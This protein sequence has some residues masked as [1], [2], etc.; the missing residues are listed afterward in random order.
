MS[1]ILNAGYNIDYIDAA[2]IN[3]LGTIPYSILILPSTDRISVATYTKIKEYISTNGAVIA[4]GKT[5]SLAPG[6]LDQGQNVKIQSLSAQLFHSKNHKAILLGSL[7]DLPDVL[8][9]A[10]PPDVAATGQTTDLGFIHRKLP[11]S[12][13]YFVVNSTNQPLHS[14]IH[15][16]SHR[17]F[18]ESWNPDTAATNLAANRAD[19]EIPLIL[20][21]YESRI[22]VLGDTAYAASL[23]APHFVEG[24]TISLDSGWRVQFG[25]T[26]S[27]QPL[28]RL[29]SWT[30]LKGRQFY[31]GEVTYTNSFTLSEDSGHTLID[32]GE[33][34]PTIDSRPPNSSGIHALLDPPIREA[35]VI[36]VNGQRAGSL[37]HPPY[38]LDITTFVHS[39]K[40]TLDIRVMNT[41]INELAGQPAR[42]YTVLNAKFGKRFDPQDMDNLK[43]LSSGLLGPVK[44]LIQE[45]AK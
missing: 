22:F 27:P 33:G 1:T 40:N 44:V 36:Y 6:L 18:I 30:D 45:R 2:T 38:R 5:P 25:N 34:T 3:K 4:L 26:N 42:D 39:G 8:H 13:I 41:A 31:S 20:A 12:D 11:T 29:T 37:W 7:A 28:P 23:P 9:K 21:P 24:P 32:F 14:T 10:L 43:P 15:F 35:G 16:R 19:S 17:P